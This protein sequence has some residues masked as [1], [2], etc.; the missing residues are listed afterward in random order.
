MDH[1]CSWPA[2]TRWRRRLVHLV[3]ATGATR[4]RGSGSPPRPADASAASTCPPGLFAPGLPPPTGV[5]T[6]LSAAQVKHFHAFGVL[7][8]K[9][10]ACSGHCAL[11]VCCVPF[12][13]S[14][15][16]VVVVMHRTESFHAGGGRVHPARGRGHP[17]RQPGGA[18]VHWDEAPASAAVL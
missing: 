14:L 7:V 4:R 3:D 12:Q 15:M 17:G 9:V 5:A 1:R 6:A 11:L 16:L 8:L 2:S 18:A 10:S 13:P